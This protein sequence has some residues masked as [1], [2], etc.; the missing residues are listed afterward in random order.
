MNTR[1]V[2]MVVVS[3]LAVAVSPSWCQII[4][5]SQS[6]TIGV[7]VMSSVST[8]APNLQLFDASLNLNEGFSHYYGNMTAFQRSLVSESSL[9]FTGSLNGSSTG[10]TISG[11]C[12]YDFT[13]DLATPNWYSIAGAQFGS[14]G[15]SF[16]P[17]T[18][19]GPDGTIFAASADNTTFDESYY[20][21]AGRYRLQSGASTTVYPNAYGSYRTSF[22]FTV[23]P[24]PSS[25]LLVVL[26]SFLLVISKRRC[27]SGS[28]D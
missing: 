28:E 16:Q 18:L 6:R 9:T 20:L 7:T 24:E 27:R 23:I 17:T 15:G 19:T 8:S 26:G 22:E 5:V 21:A 3:Q 13:F 14:G 11:N 1:L 2:V 4:P 10:L 25:I 12:G